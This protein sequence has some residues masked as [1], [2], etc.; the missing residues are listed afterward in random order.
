MSPTDSN[1]QT[2]QDA[3]DASPE[4]SGRGQAPDPSADTAAEQATLDLTRPAADD[5]GGDQVV[6]E[7]D[8]AKP[9]EPAATRSDPAARPPGAIDG[10]HARSERSRQAMVDALLELL[11]EGNIRPSSAQIAERA[12]VTQRTLFNQFGDMDSL[13]AAVAAS[14]VRRVLSML[15]DAGIGTLE[16]RAA[17]YS[18]G[19]A[20]LLEETMHVRWAVVTNTAGAE[21]RARVVQTAREFMRA[22]MAQAFAP[23]LDGVDG[24]V[25]QEVL[26]ALEPLSDP[27]AW[28]L[29]RVQ[30]GLS[31]EAATRAVHRTLLAVVRDAVG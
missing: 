29:R 8:A 24:A 19:L 15:P 23:E 5:T 18:D 1:A 25:Q 2:Q 30:Q 10:R 26:D 7:I 12:G 9:A 3:Q 6:I 4:S 11:R 14:Q 13:V 20:V 22:H 27:A 17:A 28:R 21:T 16:Q 31:V